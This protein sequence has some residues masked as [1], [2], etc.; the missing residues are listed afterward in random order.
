MAKQLLDV[1]TVRLLHPSYGRSDFGID[2]D[3][4]GFAHVAYSHSGS[5][6]HT[7]YPVQAALTRHASPE[8]LYADGTEVVPFAVAICASSWDGLVPATTTSRGRRKRSSCGL[9]QPGLTVVAPR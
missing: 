9:A 5:G 3:S 4:S 7:G 8:P 6:T 1:R 2:N